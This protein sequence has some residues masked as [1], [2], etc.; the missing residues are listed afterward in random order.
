MLQTMIWVP[1]SF[2]MA[3]TWPIIVR[4]YQILSVSTLLTTNKCTPL[5]KN[6]AS[7]D[8]TFMQTQTQGKLQ[9][10]HH[11]KWS[12]Y[13]QQFH[14][15]IKYE[16]GNTNCVGDCLNRLPVTTLT[17]TLDSC[18]HE[19]SGWP[20][21]YDIDP[22]FSTTYQMLG[23]NV[24]VNYFH[25]QDGCCIVWAISLFHQVRKRR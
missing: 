21:L 20:Q 4:H 1:F 3:T 24:V 5:C 16:T 10:Y 25:L 12:T 6:T 15:N 7:E 23:A 13:L 14:L 22:N 17:M 11:Q 9:N 18:V 19:T 2:S 8:I